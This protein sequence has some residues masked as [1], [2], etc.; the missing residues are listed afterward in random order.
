MTED[1]ERSMLADIQELG[2]KLP[3]NDF[4]ITLEGYESL[5]LLTFAFPIPYSG[6]GKGVMSFYE[7]GQGHVAKFLSVVLGGDIQIRAVIAGPLGIKYRADFKFMGAHGLANWQVKDKV[8]Q[9]HVDVEWTW[10]EA[11]FLE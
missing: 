7:T 9:I 3:M 4:I 1:Q 11:E 5:S 2:D 8:L 10:A 6:S